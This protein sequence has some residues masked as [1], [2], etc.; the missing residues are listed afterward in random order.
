MSLP[1]ATAVGARDRAPASHVT[2]DFAG[3]LLRRKRLVR[4]DGADFLVDLPHTTHVEPG[5]AFLLDTGE[6]VEVRAARE[7]LLKVTGALPRLAWH[8]GNR[9][10]PCELHDDHLLIQADPVLREMLT[11]LGAGVEEVTGPFRPEGGAYGHGRTMGHSH[12]H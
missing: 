2:L 6:A 11:Q 7:T 1:R 12:D 5:Q 8:I 10:T 9:H 4:D 3:R